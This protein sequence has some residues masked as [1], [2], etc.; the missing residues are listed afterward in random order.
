[1][2]NA[3]AGGA[4]A[5]PS[6][7]Q[8]DAVFLFIACVSLF[9]FLLVEGLLIYFAI[10]Y[11]RRKASEDAALSDVRS[12]TLLEIVWVLV[13]S[14]A[15][16]AFF[17]YG[18]V[19][20]RDVTAP[21]P[22]ASDVNV[23]AGQFLYEFKYAD[24]RTAV[25]ELRVPIGPPVKLIMT[26]RDVIHGFFIPEYRIKQDIL[27]GQYTYLY[28]QPDREGTFDIF[29]TQYCGVG[30]SNMRAKLI[31]MSPDAYSTWKAEAEGAK[32]A[33]PLF[34]KGK[35]LLER[36]GCLGCHS[37]DG[38]VKVGPTFKGLFGRMVLL[39]AG[40]EAKADEEYIRESIVDPGAK[41]VKGFPNAMP[42]FKGSVSD[43]D[44]AAIVAFLK[45]QK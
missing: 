28:F 7:W 3:F 19:V 13:P 37:V 32:A 33:L 8:I 34:E 16:L 30:H 24:G 42:T 44:M 40:G 10:R 38:S 39:E 14:L 12:N 9:F 18:Y 29:C 21:Q 22:G 27:P 15:V 31:V 4:A 35:E 45:T 17:T 43:D 41:V 23:T 1:M 36:F 2:T 11:R 25:N 26:S 6:A 5:S 20:F